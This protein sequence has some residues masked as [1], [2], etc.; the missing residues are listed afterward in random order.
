MAQNAACQP[1]S[2]SNSWNSPAGR[3]PSPAPSSCRH[4]R[5]GRRPESVAATDRLAS[6]LNRPA[7]AGRA[8]FNS[9]STVRRPK[10]RTRWRPRKTAADVVPSPAVGLLRRTDLW[11][12]PRGGVARASATRLYSS[13]LTKSIDVRRLRL[14]TSEAGRH[15]ADARRYRGQDAHGHNFFQFLDSI[16]TVVKKFRDGHPAQRG[17]HGRQQGQTENRRLAHSRRH[18]RIRRALDYRDITELQQFHTR[19]GAGFFQLFTEQ[20]VVVFVIAFVA[21]ELRPLRLFLVELLELIVKAL[22]SFTANLRLLGDFRVS[23]AHV[24]GQ[25]RRQRLGLLAIISNFVAGVELGQAQFF[26]L[27]LQL[28]Q[29]IYGSLLESL[30]PELGDPRE[31]RVVFGELFVEPVDAAFVLLPGSVRFFPCGVQIGRASCRERV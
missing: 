22:V 1:C 24:A 13:L 7:K 3:S 2:S 19:V 5:S 30:V 31:V 6:R 29:L 16:H 12:S 10:S 21:L 28:R 26:A 8:Q 25:H 23:R 11:R 4:C 20:Q 18:Q 14:S 9:T 17:E 27:A 15:Q